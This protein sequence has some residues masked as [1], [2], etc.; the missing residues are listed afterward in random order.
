MKIPLLSPKV[1][2]QTLT[3]TAFL[4]TKEDSNAP[5]FVN[6]DGAH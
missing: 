3:K 4:L 6:H 5:H 1:V 2:T